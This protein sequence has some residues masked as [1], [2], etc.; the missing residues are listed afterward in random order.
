M[1]DEQ[2]DALGTTV[3][4][5]SER[6]PPA[7]R[8]PSEEEPAEYRL[9]MTKPG[10]Y[11]LLGRFRYVEPGYAAGSKGPRS[12]IVPNDVTN[13]ETDLASIPFFAT[14]LVPRDGKNTPAALLHD[15][16]VRDRADRRTVKGPLISR[17]EAD[18]VFRRAMQELEVPPV[19]RALMWAAVNLGT[20]AKIGPLGRRLWWGFVM[21]LTISTGLVFNLVWV[22]DAFDGSLDWAPQLLASGLTLINDAFGGSHTWDLSFPSWD[23]QYVGLVVLVAIVLWFHRI[24]AG[25]LTVGALML[26]GYPLLIA[27]WSFLVYLGIEK[28][29]QLVSLMLRSFGS[30]WPRG[31]ISGPVILRK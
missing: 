18:R 17:H 22:N 29:V 3:A 19:R 30:P 12:F 25:L 8:K 7:F 26:F 11:R 6:P 20:L 14:W 27:A 5:E 15:A 16:L 13:F 1:D 23:L 2:S 9:M 31:P 24:G 4:E 10:S 28:F 21:L